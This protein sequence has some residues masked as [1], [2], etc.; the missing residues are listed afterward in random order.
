EQT[1]ILAA[2]DAPLP[3]GFKSDDWTLTLIPLDSLVPPPPA[4]S[5][6][7]HGSWETLTPF[8]PPRHVFNRQGKAKAENSVDAQVR[9]EL[10]NRGFNSENVEIRV[11]DAGWVKVH[12]AKGEKGGLS[13]M[14][15]R[16]YNIKLTFASPM[17][18]PLFLGASSHFGLGVFVP[19]GS[20]Q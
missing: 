2:A 18:G 9:T 8:V 14:D 15:K 3:L 10:E 17:S 4:L 12:Q 20:H 7:L 6:A 5:G 13:N 11:E 16:G 19:T 1:A